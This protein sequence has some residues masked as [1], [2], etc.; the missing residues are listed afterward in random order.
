MTELVSAG[1]SGSLFYLTPDNQFFVKTISANEF[2]LFCDKI[3][4][5]HQYMTRNTNSLI[6]K[7]TN[8]YRILTYIGGS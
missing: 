6:Y 3:K 4:D 1:K 8:L 2:N 5:Y 7:V